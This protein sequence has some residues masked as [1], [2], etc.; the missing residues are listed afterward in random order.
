[1][2]KEQEAERRYPKEKETG[3]VVTDLQIAIRAAKG[4]GFIEGAEWQ[5]S[6]GW[7]SVETPP[8]HCKTVLL[9]TW[10][11]AG[12]TACEVELGYYE[13]GFWRNVYTNDAFDIRNV[14]H[15]MPLPNPPKQ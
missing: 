2:N 6:Q 7:V 1:M 13:A 11:G 5:A 14:S 4:I 10:G 3:H 15:W 9:A 8:E 12:A